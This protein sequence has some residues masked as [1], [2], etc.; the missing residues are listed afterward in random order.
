MKKS[1]QYKLSVE[2]VMS[3]AMSSKR[4]HIVPSHRSLVGMKKEKGIGR[5]QERER[6]ECKSV[7]ERNGRTEQ[8]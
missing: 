3:W 5:Q 4:K 8:A 6:K 1:T 7:K 2:L